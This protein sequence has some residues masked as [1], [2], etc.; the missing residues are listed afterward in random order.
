M[1]KELKDFRTWFKPVP[2]FLFEVV[3]LH[4]QTF[5]LTAVTLSSVVFFFVYSLT[6]PY[7]PVHLQR[8]FCFLLDLTGY[9]QVTALK[10]SIFVLLGLRG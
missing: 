5:D 2:V 9:L 6:L 1:L 10:L 8:L 7:T 3:R 4:M